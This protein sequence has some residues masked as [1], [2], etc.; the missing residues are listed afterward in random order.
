MQSANNTNMRQA[1][2]DKQSAA[3]TAIHNPRGHTQECK[4]AESWK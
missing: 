3:K 4:N 2:Q 1:A